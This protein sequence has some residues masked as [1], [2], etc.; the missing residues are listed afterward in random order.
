MFH[1]DRRFLLPDPVL[2]DS[3][4]LPTDVG[5]EVSVRILHEQLNGNR[6]DRS[7]F[8]FSACPRFP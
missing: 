4:I 6:P 1:F 2:V 8:P 3:K 5:N 7:E